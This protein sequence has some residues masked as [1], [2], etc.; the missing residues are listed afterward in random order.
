MT[1]FFF[2]H[3]VIESYY[4]FQFPELLTMRIAYIIAIIATIF[5]DSAAQAK[6][7]TENINYEHQKLALQG[8]LVYDDSIT[9]DKPA[10]LIFPEWWGNNDYAKRRAQELAEKGYITFVADMYGAGKV[11][12]EKE[13]AQEWSKP[14]YENRDLMRRRAREALKVLLQQEN[15]DK[16]NIA[17]IG[18]CMGGTVAIELAR[19]EDKLKGVAAFHAGLQFPD[20]VIKGSVKAKVLV[21][22]GA[23]DPMVPAE[24]RE[25]F[26]ADMQAAN[27]DLQFVLYGKAKHAFTNPDADKYKIE[28]VGYNKKAEVRSF[29]IL[30]LFLKEVFASRDAGKR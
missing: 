4:S 22:N 6:I 2:T 3:N 14:L 17:A 8:T 24:Q 27:A 15:I 9:T 25:K 26:I 7:I 11:T 21:Q 29:Q 18:F 16:N 20:K 23:D 12:K 1:K 13:T 30:D 10:I 28:G 19:N 5:I